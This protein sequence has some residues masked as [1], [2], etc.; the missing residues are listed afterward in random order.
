MQCEG[1]AVLVSSLH[2]RLQAL[3]L[4]LVCIRSDVLRCVFVL[5]GRTCIVDHTEQVDWLLNR[6]MH[7]VRA[8]LS[9]A[10]VAATTVGA[11]HLLSNMLCNSSILSYL[12]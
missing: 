11:L 3:A 12:H 9:I 8:D 5:Q 7:T 1:S 10:A 2:T 4:P 6:A